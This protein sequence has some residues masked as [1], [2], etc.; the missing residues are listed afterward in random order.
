MALANTGIIEVRTTG[1]DNNGG[2]FNSA[3]A[4]TDWSQQTAAQQAFNGST[5]T[6]H[7]AGI[8]NVIILTGVT[9]QASDVGNYLNITGGTG[10]TVGIYEIT[11]QSSTTWT[12]DR[13]ATTGVSSGMTGNMG[14]CFATISKALAI[15]TVTGMQCYVK[16]TATYSISTGLSTPSGNSAALG[17]C[18]LIGYTTTRGDGLQPTIQTTAAIT[19]YT[20]ANGF[21]LENFIINCNAVGTNCAAITGNYSAAFNCIFKGALNFG[22]NV[23]GNGSGLYNCQITTAGGATN[24]AAVVLGLSGGSGWRV[25]NC[26]INANTTVGVSIIG[27]YAALIGNIIASNT[28][29]SSDGVLVSAAYSAVAVLMYGNVLYSNGRDGYR[30][31]AN[32]EISEISN[33]IFVSNVGIGL[34]TSAMNPVINDVLMHHNAYYNNGTARSGNNAGTGDVTLTGVPFTNAGSGDFSLNNTAS[35]GAACRSAGFPGVLVAGGTG[36]ED[37]GAL[38]HQDPSG[39]GG[40]LVHP[41]MQGGAR[42]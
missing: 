39:T 37:I 30:S 7:T 33:N 38:R 31:T 2:G 28:G 32:Y 19:A 17:I 4:G 20:D 29:A 27:T 3:A 10:F 41:G 22:A 6:A 26:Y 21:R 1:S 14:G 12:L 5:T 18:R 16:A 11:A 8:T 13:N 42:G 9:G 15:M 35:Q 23:S 40:M 36:Y 24:G 34:N 25:K